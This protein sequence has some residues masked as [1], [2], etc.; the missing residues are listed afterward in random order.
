MSTLSALGVCFGNTWGV[1]RP[2]EQEKKEELRVIFCVLPSSPP[3]CY[4]PKDPKIPP[5]HR[6]KH[7]IREL[8]T[9]MLHV[10]FANVKPKL[11]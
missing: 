3:I 2:N 10:F 7:S 8:I 4:N 1:M 6:Y 5:N 11:Q 9:H